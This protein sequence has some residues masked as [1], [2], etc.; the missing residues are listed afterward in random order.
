[1]AERTVPVFSH[2]D[3]PQVFKA[4]LHHELLRVRAV[5]TLCGW[6][7]PESSPGRCDGGFPCN[8][9]AN[10]SGFCVSHEMEVER[11]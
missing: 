6:E 11:G 8:E 10:E 4:A 3:F 7:S 1:M 9:P 5:L 2:P